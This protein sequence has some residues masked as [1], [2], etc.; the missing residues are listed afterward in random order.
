M[1]LLLVMAVQTTQFRTFFHVAIFQQNGS[2]RGNS[3]AKMQAHQRLGADGSAP[4]HE[5]IGA[6]LVGVDGIPCLVE[7]AGTVRLRA[8]AVEPVV[9]GNKISSWIA[10]DGN[11]ELAY[12]VHNILAQALGV[13]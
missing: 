8:D 5:F 7:H 6:E 9:S 2:F 4:R 1:L 11:S 12:F 13:R 3:S 10:D